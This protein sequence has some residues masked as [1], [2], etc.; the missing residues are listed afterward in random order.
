M[1]IASVAC[2]DCDWQ[3]TDPDKT[4]DDLMSAWL[5]HRLDEHDNTY[6]NKL[7]VRIG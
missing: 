4:E 3:D 2:G 5:M 1:K 7:V 6:L